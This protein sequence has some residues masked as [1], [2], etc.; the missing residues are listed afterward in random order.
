MADDYPIDVNA[1]LSYYCENYRD[2]V[3]RAVQDAIEHGTS[4]D[5]EAQI[6]TAMG[7][8]KW[9]RTIGIPVCENGQMVRIEGA[10][11]DITARKAADEEILKLSL[12]V[13]QSPESIVITNLSAEIEYVNEAFIHNTGY[14]REELIGHNPRILQSGKTPAANYTTLWDALTH[15]HTWQGELY[16]RRKDGSEYT[17]WAIITPI[18]QS[19]G[20][21]THY[22]AVKEDITEKKRAEAS[23]RE[24]NERFSTVFKT[25][26]VGMAI[27]VLADGAFLD[28]NPSFE[29]ILGY[30][31]E[32]ILGKTGSDINMWVDSHERA[33]VLNTMRAGKTVN[34]LE[35][36]FRR[37]DGSIVDIA[38]SGCPMDIGGVPHFVGMVSDITIQKAAKRT[39]ETHQAQLKGLVEVRTA[40]L[41]SAR[42]AAEAANLAKSSFLSNMSHEIRT[43]L[44]G[45]LGMAHVLRQSDI[46]P[47]QAGQLDKIAA[48]GK[49]LLGVINDILDLSKIE[50]GKL[51]FEQNDFDLSDMLHSVL[52]VT[53]NAAR[54]KGLHLLIDV[55]GLP[56]ALRGDS[57]RLSQTLVN[58]LSNAT[59]FTEQGSITLKGSLLE[60]NQSGYLLRFAVIDTGI[61]MSAD[62]QGKIF[63]A[64][65]QADSSTT[66]RYGGTGLGL[67]INRRLAD[68]MGGE[69]GVESNPGQ[70]STFWITVRLGKGKTLVAKEQQPVGKSR[71][72]LMR[73]Y[74]G[75]RILLAED[76]PINQE[77]ASLILSD[78]GL[79]VDVAG[80]GKQVLEMAQT[81]DYALILMD[82][83]MPEMDGLEATRAIRQLPG[84]KSVPILAMTA[85]AFAEDR[86]RCLKAGM[87]DFVSKPVD[88]DLFYRILLKW[89]EKVEE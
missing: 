17:E 67:T 56:Q 26:P 37:K 77:V 41:A 60:E 8:R 70:G 18:R 4:Y 34:H 61:G 27:G 62:Q 54:A 19:D 88:P 68:L 51:V 83:L 23:L 9:V 85:N 40:E 69:V 75:K 78:A 3:Q 81:Q 44:N 11:Q 35:A 48:S 7:R 2:K 59:K 46:T 30:S 74:T 29:F 21:V 38:Y 5:L 80:D 36:Q 32:E 25:S 72:R 10:I 14:S 71:A 84:R 15:N 63:K 76:E 87:N 86:E 12:A 79:L 43:P 53:G 47:T 6:L 22:V 39:L 13:A 33:V 64:F 20:S 82:M 49:H 55:A 42:D 1:G 89:L 73:E 31:R 50:A 24:I 16:N 52:A 65:E 58:F 28:L 45:I 66:R 57:T